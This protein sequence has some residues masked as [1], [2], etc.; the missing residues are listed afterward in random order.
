MACYVVE[1]VKD[2]LTFLAKFDTHEQAQAYCDELIAK[3]PLSA[4]V[5]AIIDG[6]D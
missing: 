1:K 3:D 4:D 5:L 2:G 6:E